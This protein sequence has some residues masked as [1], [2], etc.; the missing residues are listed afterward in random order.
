[1]TT[2]V[3]A[4][5][6][7]LLLA[8]FYVVAF[9]LIAGL[10]WLS[11]LAFRAG[12]GSG[13]AKLAF[14][15][16]AAAVAVVVAL[17]KVARARPQAEPGLQVSRANAPA[18]WAVVD[19]LA[20]LAQTRVPDEIRLVPE[21]NAAVSEDAR[22]LGLVGGRRR[23]YLGVPLMQALDVSQLRSVLAH[24]LGHYSNS[25]TRLG[26]LTYRGR[27]AIGATIEQLSGNVVGWLLQG[28]ARLYL[29]ASAT[30]SRRQELEADELSVRVA[31]RPVAQGTLR[32]L[33]L[34]DRAWG[35]Y[36]GA[37][38][39]AGWE[40]GYAPTAAGFF[41]GFGLLLAARGDELQTMR[42]DA[43]PAEQSRW[44]SHPSIAA[45]VAAMERMPDVAVARDTRPATGLVPGFDN[46]AAALAEQVV[47]FGDRV[48]LD[49]EA[50]T[51]TSRAQSSQRTADSVYRVAAR[52]AGQP[53]ATLATVLDLVA[54]GRLDLVLRGL[55]FDPAAGP[56]E[57][58]DTPAGLTLGVVIG[59]AAVQ[60]GVGTWRHSWS[61]PAVLVG[62]DGEPLALDGVVALAAVPGS[63]P[64][65]RA[66]LAG[67]GIDVDRA[68][69]VSQAA[70]AHGGDVIGGLATVDVDGKPAEVLVLDNGL[71]VV[72]STKNTD[73]GK[74]R[75]VLLAR[76][77]AV[78]LAARHRFVSFEDVAAA[79]V[80]KRTPVKVTVT[81]HDGTT[82]TLKE[83]WSGDRLTKDSDDALIGA[84]LSSARSASL[85]AD[86][87][88]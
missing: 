76:V 32:E 54:A 14:L 87:P 11:V 22:M 12:S 37:Y 85:D 44:D 74:E 35:F 40:A 29:L 17:V 18:L 1:M 59:S 55:G 58:G 21:V 16:L 33:P 52:V 20:V 24:E 79:E 77:P 13:G 28:Y 15:A 81:L 53:R 48:R 56:D 3:R 19:E 27:A 41:G 6:S 61:G 7:L 60:A 70:T 46:A 10:G 45:R 82:L 86:V 26:P 39:D 51:A 80:H 4:A 9:G 47:A 68:G 78:E 64:A 72:P 38:L 67:L 65:A 36:G 42:L 50:F 31:G 71:V 69:Q 2:T 49:W 66:A 23:L 62:R 8:G 83:R 43:P 84:L 25:H 73:G 63:V 88:A 34:I 30:V 5:V 57:D 75:L